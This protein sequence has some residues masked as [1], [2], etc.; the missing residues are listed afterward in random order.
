MTTSCTSPR[1]PADDAGSP[2][3]GSGDPPSLSAESTSSGEIGIVAHDI[4]LPRDDRGEHASLSAQFTS[5]DHGL[6]SKEADSST[7]EPRT[8]H[9][10]NT[11]YASIPT[12]RPHWRTRFKLQA[13]RGFTQGSAA[14]SDSDGLRREVREAVRTTDA[15]GGDQVRGTS[16]DDH[17]VGEGEQAEQEPASEEHGDRMPGRSEVAAW[18]VER[19]A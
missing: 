10:L 4:A 16:R 2:P 8:S 6:S 12:A 14:A 9:G 15:R 11:E 19:G 1:N 17:R 5:R 7:D 13:L 3:N 18:S